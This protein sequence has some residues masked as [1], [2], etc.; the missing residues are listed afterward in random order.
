MSAGQIKGRYPQVR[1]L[2][3]ELKGKRVRFYFKVI[4]YC[5]PGITRILPNE[6]RKEVI[7]D[8]RLMN[9]TSASLFPGLDGFAKSVKNFIYIKKIF[10]KFKIDNG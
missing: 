1:T 9:I 10:I 8:L 2:T 4:K 7:E 6:F 5:V 3:F